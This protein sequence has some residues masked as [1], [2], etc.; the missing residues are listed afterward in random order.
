VPLVNRF[1]RLGFW[2]LDPAEDRV[3]SS[4]AHEAKDLWQAGNVERRFAR[5]ADGVAI[6]FLPLNEMRQEVAQ[7]TPVGNQIVIDEINRAVDA[8]S[9]ELVEFSDDLGR[10]LQARNPA[11]EAR[12]IAEFAGVGAAAGKLD[13]ARK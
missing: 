2:R 7:S 12:N 13:A 1:Q 9:Q 10:R 5:E 3:E 8:A 4:L 6:A 11:V